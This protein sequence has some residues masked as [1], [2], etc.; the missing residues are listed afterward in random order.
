MVKKSKPKPKAK[1]VPRPKPELV[2]GYEYTYIEVG[3]SL[4]K[5]EIVIEV[6]RMGAQGW[7]FVQAEHAGGMY[8]IWLE[9]E[10]TG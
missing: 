3:T 5:D 2:P 8:R 1:P 6:N 4:T 9:R 7:K 10:V